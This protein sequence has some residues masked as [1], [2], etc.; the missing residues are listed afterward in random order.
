[1]NSKFRKAAINTSNRF[2]RKVGS[3]VS[4]VIP[5]HSMLDLSLARE[6]AKFI[7]L[8]CSVMLQYGSLSFGK[9]CLD[10]GQPA[11]ASLIAQPVRH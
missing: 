11:I 4:V 5:I 3:A 8:I 9:C 2:Y 1:M 10:H 7:E 6:T